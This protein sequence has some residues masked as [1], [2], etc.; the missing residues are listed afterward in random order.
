MLVRIQDVST[1][2]V[3]L[4]LPICLHVVGNKTVF[5]SKILNYFFEKLKMKIILIDSSRG[6]SK[7]GQPTLPLPS[8]VEEKPEKRNFFYCS[9]FN[10][11]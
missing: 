1:P 2:R 6:V 7:P 3:L 8:F 5:F 9:V 11:F 10:H 4:N